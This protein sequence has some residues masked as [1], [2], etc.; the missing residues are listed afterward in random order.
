MALMMSDV[1]LE[2]SVL[3]ERYAVCSL[4]AEWPVPYWAWQGDFA[5][6]TR[7]DG[8]YSIVV[9]ENAV[10]DDVVAERGWRLLKVHGPLDFSLI[11]IMARLSLPLAEAGVSIFALSVFETDYVLVKEDDL[12]IGIDALRATGI[13]VN[14]TPA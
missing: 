10:P 3:P 4:S 9:P 2:L 14:D 8:H 13:R 1:N 7:T 5:S 11:G 12:A 6:V